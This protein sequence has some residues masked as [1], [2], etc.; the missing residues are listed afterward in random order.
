MNQTPLTKVL[1]LCVPGK[2]LG[3]SRSMLPVLPNFSTLLGI[4]NGLDDTLA[5]AEAP[6]TP[7]PSNYQVEF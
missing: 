2:S 5:L 4:L 6:L 1:V 7:P 3:C